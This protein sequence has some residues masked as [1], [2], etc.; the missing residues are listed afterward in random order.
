MPDAGTGTAKVKI[1]SSKERE[2]PLEVLE[3]NFTTE[4]LPE[5]NASEGGPASTD[6]RS[7][8]LEKKEEKKEEIKL[9]VVPKE[10]E[11]KVEDKKEEEK[12]EEKKEEEVSDS[13]RFLKPPKGSKEEKEAIAKKGSR[14]TFDYTGYSQEE[15]DILKNMPVSNREKVGKLIKEHKDLASVKDTQF[16]QHENGYVLHPGYQQEIGIINLATQESRIWAKQLADV[17]AGK[18]IKPLTGWKNGQP[19]YGEEMA[20]SDELEEALRSNVQKC[21]ATVEERQRGVDAFVNNFKAIT[22][23]DTDAITTERGKRFAWVANPKLLDYSIPT[24]D[25][26]KTIKQVRS[27]VAGMFPPYMRSSPAVECVGD[28]MTA[29]F[30]AKAEI[31]ELKKGGSIKKVKDEEKE[32]IEPGSD[33]KPKKVTESV[34]GVKNFS[35]DSAP[36]VEL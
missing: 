27:D 28:L 31:E 21:Q 4:Q 22:K 2:T 10:E 6:I 18:N 12:K 16:Y 33:V 17:K 24:Q 7:K 14:D 29:L 15:T 5:L 35:L 19:V 3:K 30:I 8:P 20:A 32:A 25:G 34:H 26:D 11:K 13:S 23:R 9:E 36:G 1:E